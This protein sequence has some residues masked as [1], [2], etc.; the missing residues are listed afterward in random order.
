MSDSQRETPH[1]EPPLRRLPIGAE[2]MNSDV[3]FRVWAPDQKRVEVVLERARGKYTS[4]ELKAEANGYHSAVMNGIGPGTLYRFRLDDGDQ[5]YPDPASRFQPAGP[6]GPSM[7]VDPLA[8][9]WRATEWK[10]LSKQGQVIY[11]MHVATF[12]SEGTWDAAIGR[13][14]YLADIGITALEIMPVADFA[15]SFGW[16]YD[17]VNLFAP[18]R[19]Y[20]TPDEMR[21]FVDQAH[22]LGMGVIL[23]VVY[24]HLG[25]DGDCLRRFADHYFSKIHRTQWGDAINFDGPYSAP[26]REFV[27]SNVRYWTEEFR[28]DGLRIDA[29]QDMSD[30]SR[31]HILSE[32]SQTA[33]AA[34]RDRSV[35][36]IAENEPQQRQLV[37]PIEQGGY[38]FDM[39]WN[40]DFHHT[41]MVRL[42]GRREAY[43]TDYCGTPQE[44]VSAAKRGYLY[45][46]QF[47]RWQNKKRGSCTRGLPRSTF[48]NFLQNHDQI[49]NSGRGV[50]VHVLA[51]PALYRTM[52]ALL[53]L[54]PG[55]PMLF[56]GQEFAS[57]SPFLYFA[58]HKPEI[59]A[60]VRHGRAEFLAQ[61]PSLATPQMQ[62]V[63]TDPGDLETFRRSKLDWSEQ[64]EHEDVLA[65]HRDLLA[66]RRTDA[67][68]RALESIEV[69]GAVLSGNALVL[70]YF[71][72]DRADRL[73][74]A[75]LGDDLQLERLPEPLLAPPVDLSWA[76]LWS[77]EDPRYGGSGTP[78]MESERG[79]HVPANTVLLVGAVKSG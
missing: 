71:S 42:T 9:R 38:G 21:T 49:A 12:T 74:L 8:Y 7:I 28:L 61:F 37:D 46:G 2:F 73:V 16:G 15:G 76:V 58:D 25:P 36:I 44:L 43:Y 64:Q 59:A 20:G 26:V 69:D 24:N 4:F 35:L 53:L 27:L 1:V 3:H 41:A 77:S 70:R 23:D 13:L 40:D 67:A 63:L 57:S 22:R 32:I 75:N 33:R 50:R 5:L 18:T 29:T 31:Q 78:E 54:L 55:T 72:P 45:Q 65:L 39:L 56:Q 60:L 47:Y 19:L 79:W 68:L 6:H 17:G 66:L 11:E 52:T 34:A 14:E 51:G 10:G 48:V 62:A 30:S